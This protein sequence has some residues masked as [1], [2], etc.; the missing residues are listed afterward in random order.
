M[1]A[2]GSCKKSAYANELFI[3]LEPLILVTQVA[4]S[5]LNCFDPGISILLPYH[6]SKVQ[7]W[8]FLSV[9]LTIEKH[10]HLDI[11]KRTSTS[12]LRFYNSMLFREIKISKSLVS[13]IMWFCCDNTHAEWP[14]IMSFFWVR[15]LILKR[16]SFHVVVTWRNTIVLTPFKKVIEND[17]IFKY[18]LWDYKTKAGVLEVKHRMKERQ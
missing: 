2:L 4:K 8:W 11:Y 18:K 10:T 14:Q 12:E 13:H 6:L 9:L 1:A 15:S 5:S 3:S 17:Q 16:R 7:Q